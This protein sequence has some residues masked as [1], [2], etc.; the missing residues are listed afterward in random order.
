MSLG[1]KLK[2][3]VILMARYWWVN[4]YCSFWKVL[5]NCTTFT[6][7]KRMRSK[8]DKERE[9]IPKDYLTVTLGS[10][11]TPQVITA[12]VPLMTLWSCGGLVMRVRAVKMPKGCYSETVWSVNWTEITGIDL[13]F[14]SISL[15]NSINYILFSVGKVFC[16]VTE[17][18]NVNLVTKMSSR[19]SPNILTMTSRRKKS[20]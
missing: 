19:V 18:G 11:V 7:I 20:M 14:H 3:K 13:I 1:K 9:H 4:V 2:S 16:K 8:T 5:L 17:T 10:W 12:L 6:Y 15:W